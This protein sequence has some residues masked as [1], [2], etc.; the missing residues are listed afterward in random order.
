MNNRKTK[1]W[2]CP[3]WGV[4]A[5]I[6]LSLAVA[7]LAH[8]TSL[9]PYINALI[10]QR[11]ISSYLVLSFGFS[12]IFLAIRAIIAGDFRP[13]LSALMMILSV[14]PLIWGVM[15]WQM[16][17]V[18]VRA[19]YQI[20]MAANPT[21]TEV[22]NIESDRAVGIAVSFDTMLLAIIITT[23][24]FS[25]SFMHWSLTGGAKYSVATVK[26]EKR[27][28]LFRP[29][30]A[31]HVTAG[32]FTVL[33]G[34]VVGLSVNI[35]FATIDITMKPWHALIW[36]I[37]GFGISIAVSYPVFKWVFYKMIY[38]RITFQKDIA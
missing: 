10:N 6:L 21:A 22:V 32:I 13:R 31:Y 30:L 36:Y 34:L 35:L 12:V 25:T 1:Y 28:P 15:G 5:T 19:T 26:S 8:A 4:I 17:L 18:S 20:E 29:W 16:G 37:I 3:I 38:S 7:P 11:G 33:A 14:T 24:A 9:L 2:L 23:I 27:I